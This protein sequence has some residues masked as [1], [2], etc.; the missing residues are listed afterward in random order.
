MAEERPIPKLAVGALDLLQAEFAR[1]VDKIC[2]DT[3]E[4]LGLDPADG[5]RVDVQRRVIVKP[6]AELPAA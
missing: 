5:W 4:V 1:A 6:D 3:L 2:L